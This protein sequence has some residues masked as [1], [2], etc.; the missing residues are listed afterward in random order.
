MTESIDARRRQLLAGSVAFAAAGAVGVAPRAF[1]AEEAKSLP[2]YAAWK[3]A[4]ALIF[5]SAQTL[6]TRRDAIGMGVV[7]PSDRLFVR[8]NLPAPDPS[9][10][11]NADAWQVAF[12]GAKTAKSMT[13][14]E[15]KKLGVETVAT[16]L[17]C[18]G[19]GRGFFD[20]KASGTPW[21]TGAAGCVVWTGV[22]LR[23]VV[24]ALGG[25][26]PAARFVTSTGGESL[27]EGID[28]KT[29]VVERSVP[30]AAIDVALLAWEMNGEPLP[31]AHGGPLRL[32]VPG[33]YGVNN[34]KYVKQVAFTEQETQA[35]IQASGYRVRPV[36]EK[37]APDQPSMWEMNVKSWV[38]SPL[39]RTGS[40]R[41]QIQGVAFGGAKPIKAV[42]V[43]VDGGKS[44]QP[45]RFVGPDLGRYAW[46]P[47]VLE[48]DLKPG[49]YTLA[50][51]AT[52]ADGQSQ[53]ENFPENERGYGHNGWRRH[54]VDLTV[55]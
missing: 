20:H 15:L 12:Q 37:G 8:N 4:D 13:V 39:E 34:I 30:L 47:F 33:Y 40:G 2:P 25:V 55:A 29:L 48:A 54:A 35:K 18:S 3:E 17:Q 1:A 10:T 16:V 50:S 9:I 32:I 27:P 5:H 24:D 44:W 21:R 28:P 46:R 23:K 6:E 19:N 38:I 7:T 53:P 26:N 51:R 41:V 31:V 42:E 43:S 22:P 52:D 11:A 36:G 49:K 14:A 45:A